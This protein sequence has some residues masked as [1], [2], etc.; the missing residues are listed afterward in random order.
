MNGD[1]GL[2]GPT[3]AT[4][5]T[6]TTGSTGESYNTGATGHTG[7]TG[8]TGPTGMKGDTGF[9]GP[10][11]M[12]GDTGFTGPTGHTGMKGD[13]GFTGP[14]GHTGMKGDTGFTGSTGMK[15][16]TGFTGPT[17]MKGFT[18]M[19]GDT[20]FTGPTGMK[21]DTGFTGPTGMKGDI[22]FTGPT[23]HTGPKGDSGECVC[24]NGVKNTGAPGSTLPTSGQ[25]VLDST[26]DTDPSV[27]TATLL[28]NYTDKFNID[29]KCLLKQIKCCYQLVFTRVLL[30]SP[31]CFTT[32]VVSIDFEATYAKI[33]VEICDLADLEPFETCL[34][35]MICCDPQEL[36]CKKITLTDAN[37]SYDVQKCD[38]LLF[39]CAEED[40][41]KCIVIPKA[42]DNKCR[43]I[44]VRVICGGEKTEN[45]LICASNGPDGDLKEICY[46]FIPGTTISNTQS[47]KAAITNVNPPPLSPAHITIYKE[48]T[49][50]EIYF[51]SITGK[52][53]VNGL[54]TVAG[55]PIV[56][57]DIICA[58]ASEAGKSKFA[59]SSAFKIQNSTQTTVY[60]TGKVHTSCSKP[61]TIGDVF[62]S[63]TVYSAIVGVTEV[64]PLGGPPLFLKFAPGDK[65]D[66]EIVPIEGICLEPNSGFCITSD[67]DMTWWTINKGGPP[68]PP[69]PQGVTGPTG[70]SG[71]GP[72]AAFHF[73]KNSGVNKPFEDNKSDVD[74]GKAS[75][76]LKLADKTLGTDNFDGLYHIYCG[77]QVPVQICMLYGQDDDPTSAVTIKVYEIL[78]SELNSEITSK[79]PSVT[80]TVPAAP[81]TNRNRFI[82]F[83]SFTPS[84]SPTVWWY[85][86][87]GTQKVFVNSLFINRAP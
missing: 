43:K 70:P 54:P 63:L 39:V 26:D 18:G 16:F 49:S 24:W 64:G 87:T 65:F 13:T 22:G 84:A 68:G 73:E 37:P 6:G 12:K 69:G 44:C 29:A 61:I 75:D 23:G 8:F 20:G 81:T 41:D 15:G 9:T 47:G 4:G 53:T 78:M 59:A 50:S 74:P 19:K 25:I 58:Q 31:T 46:E 5:F 79:A 21:G 34:C 51:D 62:G 33:K 30:E 11:G 52:G 72:I 57:G 60:Q 10:T 42:S 38:K 2:T 27:K 36:N 71:N 67:G 82:T 55:V 1:T 17:G 35:M 86:Q 76:G 48:G 80:I 45:I 83:P 56:T 32:K 66:G 77:P 28:L 40:D 14:T 7:A 3:G 85:T